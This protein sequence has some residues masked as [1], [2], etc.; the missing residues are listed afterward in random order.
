MTQ[1]TKNFTLEE[2][3]RSEKAKEK[4]IDNTPPEGVIENLR[5]LAATLEEV[6]EV[7]GH[8]VKIN[9][10]YRCLALNLAIGGA[11]QSSHMTGC[12]ADIVCPGFG[13]AKQVMD[14]ILKSGILFHK[15]IYEQTWVHISIPHESANQGYDM[16]VLEAVFEPGKPV[17]YIPYKP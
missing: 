8:P 2:F 12:A 5:K 6:R 11:K 17:R 15:I 3:V 4:K 1:L 10:G 9:S 7:L 14:A 16:I 13:T